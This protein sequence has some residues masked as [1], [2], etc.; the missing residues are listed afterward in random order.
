ME[1]SSQGMVKVRVYSLTYLVSFSGL[2][3]MWYH[4]PFLI[5]HCLNRPLLK[6]AMQLKNKIKQPFDLISVKSSVE[7]RSEWIESKGK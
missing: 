7:N 4:F 1:W 3:N 5:S 6:L 2:L